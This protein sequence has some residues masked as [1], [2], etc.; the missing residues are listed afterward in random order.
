MRIFVFDRFLRQ[1]KTDPDERARYSGDT[2][3]DQS[4]VKHNID[5]GFHVVLLFLAYPTTI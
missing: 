2:C 1:L 4:A 5:K 3:K